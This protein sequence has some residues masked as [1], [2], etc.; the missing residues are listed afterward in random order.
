MK[1]KLFLQQLIAAACSLPFLSRFARADK[2]AG[3]DKLM[4]TYYKAANALT[5]YRR[6]NGFDPG[7]RVETQSRFGDAPMLGTVDKYGDGWSRCGHE[8]VPV[9][10]DKGYRQPWPMRDLKIIDSERAAGVALKPCEGDGAR[11]T[12]R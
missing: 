5:D 3:I 2:V 7:V 11:S 1:R 4:E 6:A 9:M 12:T 8:S 10:L